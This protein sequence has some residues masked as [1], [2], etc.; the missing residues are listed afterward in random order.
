MPSSFKL[1]GHPAH[2]AIIPIP[3]GELV[4]S[5]EIERVRFAGGAYR[6]GVIAGSR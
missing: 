3:L 2:P 5:S 1:L 6:R 4:L